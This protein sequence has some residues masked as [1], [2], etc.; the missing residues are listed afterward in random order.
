MDYKGWIKLHR[1]LLES[2]MWQDKPF[3]DGQAWVDLL[4]RAEYQGED[5]GT[6]LTSLTELCELWGWTKMRVRVFIKKMIQQEMI[7]VVTGNTGIANQGTLI[8]ICNY[9]KYQ[10]GKMKSNEPSTQKMESK[11]EDRVNASAATGLDTSVTQV[12]HR[13]QHRL[14]HRQSIDNSTRT[15]TMEHGLQH[16]SQHRLDKTLP[17]YEEDYKEVCIRSAR[18]REGEI[19]TYGTL[20]NVCLTEDE[21]NYIVSNYERPQELLN[22]VSIWLANH[23]REDHY[24]VVLTFVKNDKWEKRK[25]KVEEPK[26]EKE[27]VPMPDEV[28]KA[29][30]KK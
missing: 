8:L 6:F 16:R 22:N 11:N 4:L 29:W 30:L 14:Q 24:A 26:E 20:N 25:V 27:K 15:P 3:A 17:L 23:E 12:P 7:E 19:H 13:L 21:Y 2:E 18:A 10:S 1:S 5:R 28:R 9:E